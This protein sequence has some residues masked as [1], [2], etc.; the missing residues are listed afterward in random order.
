MF[1][2]VVMSLY[3]LLKAL[4]ETH[5]LAMMILILV[6][7]PISLLSV[8]NEILALVVVSGADSC[9]SLTPVS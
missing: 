8:V 2:F 4:N 1:I 7:I 5:A 3:R 9:P 6:S